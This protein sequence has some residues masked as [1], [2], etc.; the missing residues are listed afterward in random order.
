M[1]TLTGNI[2]NV[3]GS[4]LDGTVSL[5]A[6]YHR[7]VDGALVLADWVSVPLE[8][9]HFTAV[10]VE[11]GPAR[12]RV[13][14]GSVFAEWDIVIPDDGPV[15]VADVVLDDIE[16]PEPVVLAAQAASRAAQAAAERAEAGA[17]RVG[18]AEVVL[19]ARD[20]SQTAAGDAIEAAGRSNSDA[21][22]AKEEADRANTRANDAGNAATASGTSAGK[23]R[24]SETNA[25][26]SATSAAADRVQTGKD[27]T[28]TGS[29]RT[30]TAADR[31]AA[32]GSAG[33]ATTQADR[34]K[35]AADRS[36]TQ[37]DRAKT[38]ADRAK[39][40][41]DHADGAAVQA[42]TDRVNALLEG[43][44]EAYD[45]L[46]EVGEKLAAQDDVASALTSQIAGKA[47]KS[48]VDGIQVRTTNLETDQEDLADDLQL[49]ANKSD[50]VPSKVVS[51][52]P[53]SPVVGTLYFVT[54]A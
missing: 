7:P 50:V 30:A 21:D 36:T 1:T 46:R 33:T 35:S 4:K 27:R 49:K 3:L 25:A 32:A 5:A 9:S 52:M 47:D 39:D 14:A 15:D 26:G 16:Y 43:A 45:T 6:H 13:E 42:V 17:D 11:P 10:D 12:L 44:P 51:S 40:A 22:R 28:A 2:T 8:D 20:Q 54:G 37:A 34:A 23:A 41:A 38:E 24:T 19:E 29:D 31:T 53:S 18:S 48:Y